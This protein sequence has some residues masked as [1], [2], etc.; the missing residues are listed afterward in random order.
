MT[1]AVV[2]IL[3]ELDKVRNIKLSDGS[4]MEDFDRG[5]SQNDWIAYI[6]AYTGRAAEKVFRNQRENCDFRSNMVKAAGLAI[7]AIEAYDKGYCK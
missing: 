2:D 3:Q 7:A 6:N 5:N 1:N 4:S